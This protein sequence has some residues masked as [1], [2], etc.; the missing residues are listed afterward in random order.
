MAEA[1]NHKSAGVADGFFF[2]STRNN[3]GKAR[4]VVFQHVIGDALAD[5]FD[6][7]FL[8]QRPRDQNKGYLAA[9]LTNLHQGVHAGPAGKPVVGQ[10]DVVVKAP[11][12]VEK[13]LTR[14]HDMR[15][16][17]ESGPL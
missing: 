15:P 8:P 4:E 9:G 3:N 14:A 7:D 17:L 10:D 2:E 11:K 5:T 1:L 6:S 13:L 12:V 16:A